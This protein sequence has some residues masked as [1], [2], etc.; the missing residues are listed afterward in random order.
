MEFA[1]QHGGTD[2]FLPEFV[3]AQAF[4][5][6]PPTPRWIERKVQDVPP[7]TD[8]IWPESFDVDMDSDSMSSHETASQMEDKVHEFEFHHYTA[9]D[10]YADVGG[11]ASESDT[12]SDPGFSCAGMDI[13]QDDSESDGGYS[14]DSELGD[15]EYDLRDRAAIARYLEHARNFNFEGDDITTG[16]ALHLHKKALKAYHGL[17]FCRGWRALSTGYD[18]NVDDKLRED[19]LMDLA[20]WRADQILFNA[21]GYEMGEF[22]GM[23]LVD[24][25]SSAGLLWD[26]NFDDEN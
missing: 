17:E 20:R 11:S 18:G 10:Y 7:R 25:G 3:P 24:S 19:E 16:L 12:D 2:A 15:F 1:P 9:A 6:C 22:D 23:R 4:P 8:A 13:D 26:G 5:K 21:T 14:A